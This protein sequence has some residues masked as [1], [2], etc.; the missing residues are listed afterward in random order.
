MLV[1]TR[2]KGESIRIGDEIEIRVLSVEGDGIKLGI[3]APRSLAVY[4]QEIYEAIQLSNREAVMQFKVDRDIG[5]QAMR[6]QLMSSD[7]ADHLNE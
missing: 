6:R 2:K 4:R 3:I 1:L 5:L 7:K